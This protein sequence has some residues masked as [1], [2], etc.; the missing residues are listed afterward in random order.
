M[1]VMDGNLVPRAFV[2]NK[3]DS[4]EY[5]GNIL[6]YHNIRRFLD[7]NDIYFQRFR[8]KA[9]FTLEFENIA[10]LLQF[11]AYSLKKGRVPRNTP[12][13]ALFFAQEKPPCPR[14][15]HAV[16]STHTAAAQ[17]VHIHPYGC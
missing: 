14:L 15:I 12:S 5:P 4:L 17:P 16:R 1:E 13:P 8:R 6:V 10:V 7:D 2:F 9:E 11:H 3:V